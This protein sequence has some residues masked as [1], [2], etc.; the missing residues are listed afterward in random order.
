MVMVASSAHNRN[1]PNWI[2]S[3]DTYSSDANRLGCEEK[4]AKPFE[5][6]RS[7]D[8]PNTGGGVGACNWAKWSLTVY[9]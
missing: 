9:E 7:F 2:G 1:V 3:H 8:N 5:V 4:V 6:R